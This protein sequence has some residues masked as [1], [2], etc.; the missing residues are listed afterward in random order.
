MST[1]SRPTRR[2]I[3]IFG[4]GLVVVP[5]IVAVAL[6][7]DVI[8][9]S[10][11]VFGAL[12]PAVVGAVLGPLLV[13]GRRFRGARSASSRRKEVVGPVVIAAVAVLGVFHSQLPRWLNAFFD[14]L[15]LGFFVA[16]GALVI[17]LWATNAEFRQ[18]IGS[19]VGR[20]S[21]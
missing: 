5:V 16:L 18:R 11:H 15:V 13:F 3:A 17:H 4:G 2:D 7:R 9:T 19:A 12:M 20:S 21:S 6:A 14:G 8:K 1:D 10:D